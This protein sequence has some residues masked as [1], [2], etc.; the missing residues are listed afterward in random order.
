MMEEG[1]TEEK[2]PN[3]SRKLL[4]RDR[5]REDA[6]LLHPYAALKSGDSWV[7]RLYLPF[8]QEYA[9]ISE[10]DFL[11]LPIATSADVLRR[12]KMRTQAGDA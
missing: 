11:R 10:S 4:R 7:I 3:R 12:A 5:I 9:E 2:Y 1:L 8:L 6:E